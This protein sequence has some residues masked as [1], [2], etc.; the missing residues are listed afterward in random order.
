MF[1]ALGSHPCSSICLKTCQP[2]SALY[3]AHLPPSLTSQLVSAT[4]PDLLV[5]TQT[6]QFADLFIPVGNK[7]GNLDWQQGVAIRVGRWDD[8]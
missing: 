1:P 2:H 8:P 4:G 7:T 3:L 5:Y 6:L